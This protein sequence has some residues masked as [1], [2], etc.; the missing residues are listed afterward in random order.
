LNGLFENN[1][2]NDNIV[3][4]LYGNNVNISFSPDKYN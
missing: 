3:Y 1:S 2:Y 4:C